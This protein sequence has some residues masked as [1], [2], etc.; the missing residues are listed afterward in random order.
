MKIAVV[1]LLLKILLITSGCS[2]KDYPVKIEIING[3]SIYQNPNYPKIKNPT[4]QLKEELAIGIEEGDEN[5]LFYMPN[6]VAVDSKENI[7]VLEYGNCR[8]QVYN[9]NGNYL[10]TISRKGQGPGEI[11]APTGLDIDKHDNIYLVD[12]IMRRVTILNPDGTYNNNFSIE[13]GFPMHLFVDGQGSI[14]ISKYQSQVKVN[15]G[16]SLQNIISIYDSNGKCLHNFEESIGVSRQ[17]FKTSTAVISTGIPF[18][19][20]TVWTINSEGHCYIGVSS[21]YEI[22]VY[23]K[24]GEIVQKFGVN[25]SPKPIK[26]KDKDE[27]L[28]KMN[29]V[30]SNFKKDIVFNDVKPF[31]YGFIAD[32]QGNIW[33]LT[34]FNNQSKEYTYDVF[35]AEGIY[36]MKVTLSQ[37]PRLFKDGF[38]YTIESTE[39]G[40]KQV[41]KYKITFD[42]NF[43]IHDTSKNKWDNLPY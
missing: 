30:P 19:P 5:Y 18:S 41:K 4:V 1:L 9:K 7:Y 25:R 28:E 6:D 2:N 20:T 17:Q 14:F 10:R 11:W 33:I 29:K 23:N 3:I 39:K 31:F 36:S 16:F 27:A 38:M 43:L 24:Q 34:E 40:Y 42:K 37:R 22:S 8:L 13:T 35:N 21:K 26:Q 15:S 32:H 12:S